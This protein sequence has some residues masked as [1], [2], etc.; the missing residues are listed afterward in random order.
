MS[1]S[2][3]EKGGKKRT[4]IDDDALRRTVSVVNSRDENDALGSRGHEVSQ[5][6]GLVPVEG[7]CLFIITIVKTYISSHLYVPRMS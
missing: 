4:A 5:Y 6:C 3:R 1:Q 2:L 7:R